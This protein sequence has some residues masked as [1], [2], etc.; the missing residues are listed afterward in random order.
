MAER[1]ELRIWPGRVT[2]VGEFLAWVAEELDG[3]TVELAAADRYR[4][5]EAEDAMDGAN[6]GWAMVWRAQGSGKDGSEDI[7]AFQRAVE[8]GTLR[9]GES[10]L[11]RSAIA[12]SM[13]RYD[14]NQN[15][16]LHKG[17]P[18]RPDR[19]TERGYSG[20]GVGLAKANDGRTI[21]IS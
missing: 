5:A 11:L 3:E 14:A 1:G 16:A 20:R 15:P 2:P 19:R 21:R 12:E 7:R 18:A 8:G 9:P 6:L 10:L 13:L 4:Q 17:T